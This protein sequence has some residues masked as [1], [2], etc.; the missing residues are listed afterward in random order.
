DAADEMTNEPDRR[1]YEERTKEE[2]YELAV[3]RDIDGRSLMTKD[4][5]IV[6]LRE[7]RA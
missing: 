7:E 3:E 5:L 1:T 6:A 2:L 4:E